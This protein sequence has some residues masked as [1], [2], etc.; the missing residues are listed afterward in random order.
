MMQRKADPQLL[1]VGILAVLLHTPSPFVEGHYHGSYYCTS[2]AESL[3][4]SFSGNVFLQN[5]SGY[6]KATE[7][8]GSGAFPEN[9][10]PSV[11]VEAMSEEDVQAAVVFAGECGYTV[12]SR[13]AGHS[14]VGTSSCNAANGACIQIDVSNLN[15]TV[16]EG[17]L[18]MAGPGMTLRQMADVCLAN[19]FHIPSG[20]CA[21]VTVGGH[22]QTGGFGVW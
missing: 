7:Q 6:D 3:G 2:I 1:L 12:S 20:E 14:Y 5:E 18:L 4:E 11:I 16:V 22:F 9:I 15:H 17:D 10:A 19:E 13:S 21:A 8:F